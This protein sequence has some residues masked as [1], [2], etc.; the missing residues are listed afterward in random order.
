MSRRKVVKTKAE[1]QPDKKAR[2]PRNEKTGKLTRR[3][4]LG[5]AC[6]SPALLGKPIRGHAAV[7]QSPD[8]AVWFDGFG[9]RTVPLSPS[10][11]TSK[12]NGMNVIVV[13]TDT[14]RADHFGCHG[15]TRVKTPFVDDFAKK[16]VD[17]TDAH[18]EGTPTI[19]CR[20]VMH[21]GKSFRTGT[22]WRPLAPEDITLA[23][24]LKTYGYTTAFI[25]DTYHH[26]K[27]G[28]NY[29][30]SFD[31]WE[32]IRGQENDK[33][34]SGPKERFN[35]KDHVPPH[36]WD[37]QYHDRLMQYLLN[38]QHIRSEDDYFCAR[39]CRAA[40]DWLDSNK[41]SEPFLLW[42]ETFDPH[43]PWDAPPRFQ[44]MYR[45]DY[46]CERT[47]FGYGIDHKRVVPDD[48]PLLRDLYAA[49]VSY[50]DFIVG[51][52]LKGIEERGL[53]EN[54]IILFTTDHG[55]HLGEEGC[56]Q[57]QAKLLNQCYTHIPF[58]IKHPDRG[59]AGKKVD[60]PVSMID[61]V[62]TVLHMLGISDYTNID[63]ESAWK[64]ANGEK[65]SIHGCVHTVT[66]E[67]FASAHNSEWHFFQ[68][69]KG[70]NT[71]LG[72]ALY[73]N[74]QDPTHSRN[75]LREHVDIA[76]E[77]RAQLIDYLREEI[78]PLTI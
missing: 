43:E 30:L 16:S 11:R 63:G 56:I 31:A 15:N 10:G 44:K 32:W 20:R 25:V 49:E 41:K 47:I 66:T 67:G 70:A 3:A 57:K 75:V 46:P 58:I 62:P 7:S 33:W 72:P 60:A 27:P 71:G 76:R 48:Y 78:P 28:Y 18:T 2:I 19:P 59:F 26:F 6:L 51:R 23:E 69:Y 54:S 42:F 45:N 61:F 34:K 5:A 65:E 17:F 52:L 50:T 14:W 39:T 12:P 37:E 38:T 4:F 77:L 1:Q 8:S 68:H 36:W 74:K 55:T 24:V 53:F 9:R 73:N 29:H 64:L 13:M 35:T 40:L 21:T 22:Q